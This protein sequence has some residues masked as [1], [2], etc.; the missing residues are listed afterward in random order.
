[1][2]TIQAHSPVQEK[3][4][5]YLQDAHAMEQHV[6]RALDSLISTTSDPEVLAQLKRHKMDTERHERILRE[7]LEQLGSGPSLRAEVPAIMGA[8]LKSLA[9]KVRADKPG[10]NARDGFVTEQ[11]EIA[12]Y[13][14]LQ[15]LAQRAGDQETARIARDI[16][17]DEQEMAHWIS[18]RWDKFIDLTLAETGVEQQTG[19]WPD[20][21][22]R[23]DGMMRGLAPVLWT[24]GACVGSYFLFRMFNQGRESAPF[25][26]SIEEPTRQ[27]ARAMPRP[28]VEPTPVA[29]AGV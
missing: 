29:P 22:G 8:W 2:A 15:R 6:L 27:P 12:A 16:L 3:V 13:E 10:K 28:E 25:P 18:A 21:R 11:V 24:V 20:M 5:D 23:H 4:I 17:D 14:L 7:R 1:M 19:A 26:G 9:D